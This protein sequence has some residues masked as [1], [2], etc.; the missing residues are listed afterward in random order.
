MS[1]PLAVQAT[2]ASSRVDSFSHDLSITKLT[3]LLA[4]ADEYADAVLDGDARYFREELNAHHRR[5]LLHA[6]D[7][8]E[9]WLVQWHNAAPTYRQAALPAEAITL[10]SGAL[11]FER[12]NRGGQ[13]QRE[14]SPGAQVS[15]AAGSMRAFKAGESSESTFAVHSVAVGGAPAQDAHADVI[16]PVDVPQAVRRG[17]RV[18]DVRSQ[19]ERTSQGPL[20]GAI[21][22]DADLAI[23]RL[24]PASALRLRSV[25]STDVEWIIVSSDG[26]VAAEIVR[27]LRQ[28]G[29]VYSRSMAGGFAALAE[30]LVF[31]VIIGGI[32][33]HRDAAVMAAH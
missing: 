30:N 20:L 27:E 11:S 22:I 24:D 23:H 25:A 14:L 3:K 4:L 6:D 21:A 5:W 33:N 29:L 8:A 18:V 13:L 28:R 1:T 32:H 7:E 26:A 2:N 16:H 9:V 31:D 17:A 10:L 15:F 19:E 12:W